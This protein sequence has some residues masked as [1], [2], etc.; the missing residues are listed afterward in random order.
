MW[1]GWG[2]LLRSW[3]APHLPRTRP[4]KGLEGRSWTLEA[5]PCAGL[6]LSPALRSAHW[7]SILLLSWPPSPVS[8]ASRKGQEEGSG[9]MG[10]ELPVLRVPL[11]QLR[12]WGREA[13]AE[14]KKQGWEGKGGEGKSGEKERREG[15]EGGR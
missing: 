13:Q 1:G 9:G 10:R 11:G 12:N 3:G 15:G 2:H 7:A 5:P 4:C 8:K 6:G 14:R